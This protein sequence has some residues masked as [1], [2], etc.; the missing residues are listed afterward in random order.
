M[1]IIAIISVI[2]PY[3]FVRIRLLLANMYKGMQKKNETEND[4]NS[5]LM[6][7]TVEVELETL[8]KYSFWY[9]VAGLLTIL[10]TYIIT[11]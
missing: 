8:C 9:M 10:F 6:I 3:L 11:K 5:L 1:I 2:F 4:I 7:C